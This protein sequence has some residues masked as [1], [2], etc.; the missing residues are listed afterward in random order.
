MSA[1]EFMNRAFR[2]KQQARAHAERV[3]AAEAKLA[4]LEEEVQLRSQPGG[5]GLGGAILARD[6]AKEA[7][8]RLKNPRY[9]MNAEIRRAAGKG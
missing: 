9:A 6:E 8:K 5:I 3:K 4:E 7:L 2:A 1:G